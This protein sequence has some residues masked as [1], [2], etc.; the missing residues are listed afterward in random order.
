MSLNGTGLANA[1]ICV[2]SYTTFRKTLRKPDSIDMLQV[3]IYN[4]LL[5]VQLQ[6]RFPSCV[7]RILDLGQR[8]AS[9]GAAQ[10]LDEALLGLLE[11]DDVPNGIEVLDRAR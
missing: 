8:N 2:E 3:L 11:V 7:V 6:Y 4:I 1:L 5:R 9:V 10:A